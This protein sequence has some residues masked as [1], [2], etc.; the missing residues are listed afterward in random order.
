MAA[1]AARQVAAR[2]RRLAVPARVPVLAAKITAPGVPGWAVPR[3]RITKLI[4]QGTRWWPL[5]VVT[6]PA[7]AGKTTAL[8]LWAAAEPGTVA[9]VSVDKFDTRPGVFWAHVVGALR[10]SGRAVPAAPPAARGP[11][12][13][14][15]LVLGL[16]AALAPRTRR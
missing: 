11:G 2:A 4:V 10:R 7:G 15:V 1:H 5:T 3:A 6:A 12:A 13:G 9:W 14:H 16:A 8:A